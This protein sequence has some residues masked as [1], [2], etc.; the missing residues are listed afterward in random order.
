VRDEVRRMVSEHGRFFEVHVAA[1]LAVCEQRDRKG[2]AKARAGQIKEFTGV[3]D[4]YE[5]PLRPELRI[6]TRDCTA[7]EA[8]SAILARLAAEGYVDNSEAGGSVVAKGGIEPP[9][10]GFSVRCSTN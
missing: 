1:P 8:A 10:R 6:D 3:S 4:P 2:S 7:Q 9:T 5:A